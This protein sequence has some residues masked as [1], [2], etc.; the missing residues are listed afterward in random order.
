MSCSIFAAVK[1]SSTIAWSRN[2]W[3]SMT[4]SS[5]TRCSGV[6][7]RRDAETAPRIERDRRAQLVADR[8]DELRLHPVRVEQLRDVR[9][10]GFVE[11]RLRDRR[12][13]RL[14]EEAEHL[15]VVLVEVAL[16]RTR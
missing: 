2:D 11:T 14:G 10:L 15:Q 1:I 13:D 5:S 16:G 3:R 6:I 4:S 7:E 8:R 9:A 12:G